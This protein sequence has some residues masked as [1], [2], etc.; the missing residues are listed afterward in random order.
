MMQCSKYSVWGKGLIK[1]RMNI[2]LGMQ[3]SGC[4]SY[5]ICSTDDPRLTVQLLYGKVKFDC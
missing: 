3:H 2:G 4:G 5:R 1:S